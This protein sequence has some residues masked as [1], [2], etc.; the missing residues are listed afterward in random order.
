MKSLVAQYERFAARQG[1]TLKEL[2]ER[3]AARGS[4]ARSASVAS[5]ALRGAKV[6][7]AQWVA[8]AAD[9]LAN[10][11][12][13]VFNLTLGLATGRH[14]EYRRTERPINLARVLDVLMRVHAEE[15]FR[16]GIFNADP[17]PG[18]IMLLKDGRIGLI[19]YVSWPHR[20]TSRPSD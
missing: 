20:S 3:N 17:H 13:W 10:A 8:A 6:L 19:D 12:R 9:F 2:A 11:P 1:L 4:G 14:L 16:H 18:N 15:I 7:A 5:L